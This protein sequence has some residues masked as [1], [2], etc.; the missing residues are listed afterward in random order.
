MDLPQVHTPSPC[1]APASD[2][3]GIPESGQPST[4]E[5]GHAPDLER[6]LTGTAPLATSLPEAARGGPFPFN[7]W[8][9]VFGGFY[10]LCTGMWRKAL[11]LGGLW[12]AWIAGSIACSRLF[13]A[14]A[15]GESVLHE[16]VLE[17]YFGLGWLLACLAFLFPLL[18]GLRRNV[19]ACLVF[20]SFP[21]LV[22][23]GE[24]HGPFLDFG[25]F[26]A[27]VWLASFSAWT[28]MGT[29]FFV[30]C[31]SRRFTA[32][33]GLGLLMFFAFW[34]GLPLPEL[35][36]FDFPGKLVNVLCGVA[37]SRDL[38]RSR[39]LKERFWW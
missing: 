34:G 4:Q 6:G 5:E 17:G 18:V 29:A 25:A 13:P 19:L 38:Y 37:A 8:A 10:Y 1:S 22:F 31:A 16:T 33:L 27:L 36:W 9:Y 35:F 28:G 21:V 3:S 12:L 39:Q 24:L 32:A 30:L 23:M 15:D 2:D 11:L 7:G 26:S 20:L 14:F